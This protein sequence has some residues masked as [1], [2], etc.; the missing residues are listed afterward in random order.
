MIDGARPSTVECPERCQD[1]RVVEVGE[2]PD[3]HTTRYEQGGRFVSD[4]RDGELSSA[5]VGETA[6]GGKG[7]ENRSLVIRGEN[8]RTQRVVDAWLTRG[9][10]VH[11]PDCAEGLDR[12]ARNGGESRSR[13]LSRRGATAQRHLAAGGQLRAHTSQR[14]TETGRFASE[15]T[16]RRPRIA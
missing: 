3:E 6:H 1:E 2:G 16:P 15:A 5:D 11:A 12:R 4:S 10:R 13:V 7:N 9:W 14:R 8:R